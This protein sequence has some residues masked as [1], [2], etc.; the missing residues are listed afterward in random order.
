[1][2]SILYVGH[3]FKEIF[4]YVESLNEKGY[5]FDSKNLFLPMTARNATTATPFPSWQAVL[6]PFLMQMSMAFSW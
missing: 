3:F 1:M 4:P 6:D 2:F 5:T